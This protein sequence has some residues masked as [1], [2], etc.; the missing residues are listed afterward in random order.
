MAAV[1]MEEARSA[2]SGDYDLVVLDELNV[3]VALGVV[4]VDDTVRLVRQRPPEVELVITGRKAPPELLALA[5]LVTEMRAVRHYY[6]SGVAARL[7]IE[8]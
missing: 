4:D 1:G 5:D 2:L 8:K 6:D 3:A 7:G